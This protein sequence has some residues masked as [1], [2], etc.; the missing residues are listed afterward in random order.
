MRI[1]INLLLP[2][3]PGPLNYVDGFLGALS[4]APGEHD[5]LVLLRR[6][7]DWSPS[8]PL[9]DR[10]EIRR[11]ALNA[12]YVPRVAY[13]QLLMPQ[14]VF[15]WQA[16]VLFCPFDIAPLLPRCA[17]LLA[18]RNPSPYL[19]KA[20]RCELS[21][22]ETVKAWVHSWMARASGRIARRV[23]YPTRFASDLLGGLSNVPP[24]KRSVIFHGVDRDFWARPRDAAFLLARLNL[25]R[26][27]YFL[28]V[29]RFYKYKRVGLLADAFVR[30]C[31][32]GR[33][34]DFKLVLVGRSFDAAFESMLL[35]QATIAG[36]EGRISILGHTLRE[37][38]ASLY[39]NCAG[40]VFP[41]EL[42]TFG[43]PLAEAIC[44]GVP[45]IACDL[46]F[47]R[48]ICGESALYFPAGDSVAL[49]RTLD[50]LANDPG[51]WLR[52]AAATT[53]EARKFSWRREAEETLKLAESVGASVGPRG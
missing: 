17:V 20:R 53:H 29:S 35:K 4:E 18:V 32:A 33:A 21:F 52:L 50:A 5:F 22:G 25:K 13:E 8:Y 26:R 45:V 19:L 48:E 1:A 23:F 49:E 28:F 15:E 31:K 37:D 12:G 40:F 34:G 44:S 9:G 39:Q 6:S 27:K 24:E 7:I 51:L 43:Q 30:W 42:E 36:A 11:I 41:S 16:D 10:M 38:L 3:T 2:A 46:G 14:V 47:A